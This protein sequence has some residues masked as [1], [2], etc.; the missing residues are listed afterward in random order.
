MRQIEGALAKI[1]AMGMQLE[2]ARDT[3]PKEWK[4]EEGRAS[5]ERAYVVSGLTLSYKVS[6]FGGVRRAE[7]RVQGQADVCFL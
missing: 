1:M 4:E 6:V 3:A 2:V 7:M 5:I